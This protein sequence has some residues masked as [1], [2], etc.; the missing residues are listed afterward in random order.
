MVHTDARRAFT[1][2]CDRLEQTTAERLRCEASLGRSSPG[3]SAGMRRQL[4]QRDGVCIWTGC[5]ARHHL[6]AHH[7]VHREHG[8][9]TRLDNLVI[10]CGH[11][12]RVL[13]R[14][15]YAIVRAPDGQWH[16]RRPDGSVIPRK[17][18]SK[19]VPRNRPRFAPASPSSVTSNWKG[20]ALDTRMLDPIPVLRKSTRPAV[21]SAAGHSTSG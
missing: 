4:L 6:H 11:H 1:G 18:T 15:G 14:E 10:L 7:V 20:E 9:A 16:V 12:H 19:T 3:V 5:D 2:D 21:D 13:H 17:I 8:G